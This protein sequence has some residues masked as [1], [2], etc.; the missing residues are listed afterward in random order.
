MF[1]T[2]GDKSSKRDDDYLDVWAS[3]ENLTAV[4]C[5]EEEVVLWLREFESEKLNRRQKESLAAYY[6]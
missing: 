3:T 4:A 5:G 6:K 2:A 1:G